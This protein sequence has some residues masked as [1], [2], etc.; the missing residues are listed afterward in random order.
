MITVTM[1]I[2]RRLKAFEEV[3]DLI[4]Q[5]SWRSHRSHGAWRASTVR[6]LLAQL[7]G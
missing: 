3:L 1:K 2:G 4:S 5:C 6:N 7:P